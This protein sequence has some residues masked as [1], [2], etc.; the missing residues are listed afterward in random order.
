MKSV[1]IINDVLINKGYPDFIC[2]STPFL[3]HFQL[4]QA[5]SQ[6]FL[7]IDVASR[8][9]LERKVVEMTKRVGF[10]NMQH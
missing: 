8:D 3:T 6:V 1:L 7:E 5:F 4:N 9:K 2:P 10:H